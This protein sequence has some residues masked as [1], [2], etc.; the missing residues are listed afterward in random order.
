MLWHANWMPSWCTL[1]DFSCI[2]IASHAM[3]FYCLH[4]LGER[5]V[6]PTFVGQVVE[7]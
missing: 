2:H 5:E 1:S 3:S 4:F 7:E 6:W